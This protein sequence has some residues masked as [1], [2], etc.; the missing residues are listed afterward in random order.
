MAQRPLLPSPE[1]FWT[2]IFKDFGTGI[3]NTIS[4]V[5][6]QVVDI[7]LQH[8]LAALQLI[9]DMCQSLMRELT[10]RHHLPLPHKVVLETHLL[11][12]LSTADTLTYRT[13]CRAHL[14]HLPAY[15]VNGDRTVQILCTH[16]RP[17]LQIAS[18]TTDYLD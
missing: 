5:M 8:K 12:W 13:A 11:P 7:P 3:V 4:R 17:G 15:Y 9:I 2:L 16:F 18:G 10:P 6:Y 1:T 14:L